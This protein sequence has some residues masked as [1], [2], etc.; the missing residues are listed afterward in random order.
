MLESKKSPSYLFHRNHWTHF[1]LSISFLP[2]RRHHWIS[3]YWFYHYSVSTFRATLRW[4][5]QLQAPNR[6]TMDR[7]EV[8]NWRFLIEKQEERF[9]WVCTI[10]NFFYCSDTSDGGDEQLLRPKQL[11][12]R[13]RVFRR[14]LSFCSVFQNGVLVVVVVVGWERNGMFL[15][16]ERRSAFQS[17]SFVYTRPTRSTFLDLNCPKLKTRLILRQ[18]S[19]KSMRNRWFVFIQS[20]TIDWK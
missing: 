6:A 17:C 5:Q 20:P 19:A 14:V 8:R 9:F 3:H 18:K 2:C 13:L 4:P 10:F 15:S 16:Y 12:N 11:L 1:I 7:F